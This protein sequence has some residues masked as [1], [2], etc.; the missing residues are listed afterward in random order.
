MAEGRNR[1]ADADDAS[2]T[3]M[4]GEVRPDLVEAMP[5]RQGMVLG[6]RYAIEKIIG[7]GASGVVVRAHDSELRQQVAIKIVR[8][9]LVGQRIWASRLAREVKLARQIQ[10][11]NVCRV[12]NFE[13]AEGRAFLV[14]ELAEKGS[15]RDELRSGELAARPLAA[16][17]A[18]ARAVAS[19]LAAIHAAGIVHRDLSPQNMLRMGD[20]RLV[21]S[22]FGLATDASEN[23]SIHGGTVA[24]MAPEV[25]LG[26][27][28][29][30][31][32][33]IWSLGVLMHEMVFGAK[34]R[35]PGVAEA[36]EM[37]APELGRKLTD[38]E[39][40]VLDACRACAAKDPA[41]RVASAEE[42][43][44]LLTERRAWLARRRAPPRWPVVLVVV[45]TAVAVVGVLRMRKPQDA[46]MSA[47]SDSPLVILSGHPVD[48]TDVSVVLAEIP[49]RIHCSRLLPDQR[50]VRIVWGLPTHAEDVDTVTRKRVASPLVPAAYAEGCPDLSPDGTRLVYQGHTTDRRA[51]AFLSQRAD[52]RDAVAVVPTAEPSMSSE[53]TWL[54]DN[55]T[56]SFDVDPKHMGVFSTATGRMKILPEVTARPYLTSFRYVNGN[57]IFIAT[58][59]ETGEAEVSDISLPALTQG[60]KFRLPPGGY[61]LRPAGSLLYYANL[62]PGQFQGLVE[63]NLSTREGRVLGRLRQQGI[64]YPLF[65]SEGLAFVGLQFGT[66][67]V[68]DG[69]DGAAHRWKAEYDVHEAARCGPDVV[70]GAVKGDR[71]AIERR[72]VD[73]RLVATVTSGPWD[74]D[75]N[76]SP[77]GRVLFYLRQANHPGIVR[78]DTAGCRTM[79]ER[80]AVSLT[81]SPDGKRLALVSTES[82]RGPVVEIADAEG[83]HIRE[84]TEIETGCR[85]GWASNGTLWVER[86]RGRD[87]VWKEIDATTA[88]ETGRSA[89]GSRDCAD[90]KPDPQS[91]AQRDVRVIYEQVS[92]LRFLPKAYLSVNDR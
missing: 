2:W 47:P 14:M 44:R 56:F 91:P 31:A 1:D 82:K 23:T 70:V 77:D 79:V 42:A 63:A 37:L 74:T 87:V 39:R 10:H 13:Q 78:C 51:F 27:N 84:L 85:P 83:G 8:A 50:T 57:R 16:R 36:A 41:R 88:Q 7:R 29:S 4:S 6:G 25:V 45:L 52:G 28:A 18:D 62:L 90:G 34:P 73:G 9:E 21:L 12:F 5:I 19:A 80:Q 64:R 17:I 11:A 69:P 65:T 81:I 38:D 54:S 72:G 49:D 58:V 3:D 86:R 89:P 40:A 24:Y 43:G 53:P 46:R 75:P 61:D 60:P 59:F 66:T 33:D 71:M 20:G 76:C 32:S 67:V 55:D 68:V 92:Q 35:W 22:D 15:L 48:W 26:G 30:V